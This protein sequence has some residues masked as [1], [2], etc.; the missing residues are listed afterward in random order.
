MSFE[1]KFASLLKQRD[2]VKIRYN[3]WEYLHISEMANTLLSS[4]KNLLK[5]AKRENRKSIEKKLR[6]AKNVYDVKR[7]SLQ[8]KRKHYEDLAC[9]IDGET[10]EMK[11]AKDYIRDAYEIL[12][13]MDLLGLNEVKVMDN[14]EPGYIQRSRIFRIKKDED[15]NL[16]LVPYKNKNKQ[17]EVKLE[18]GENPSEENH[19]DLDVDELLKSLQE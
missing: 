1:L 14:D 13:N 9:V 17:E 18:E 4:S 10:K 3:I 15:G 6:D 16:E 8:D 11:Q 5:S 7:I 2:Q 12:H 19:E